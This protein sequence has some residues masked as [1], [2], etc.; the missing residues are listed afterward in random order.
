MDTKQKIILQIKSLLIVHF[1]STY[2]KLEKSLLAIFKKE[3]VGIEH[4]HKSKL[5][6][7]YGG[8]IGTNVYYDHDKECL[9]LSG[10]KGYDEND[11]FNSLNINKII[12]FSRKNT[13]IDG[14]KFDIDSIQNKSLSFPFH[15]SCNKLINMRNKLAHELDLINFKDVDIIENL[16]SKHVK[17]N[18][19]D[20]LDGL[21][22]S[23]MDETSI[24]IFSNLVYMNKIITQLNKYQ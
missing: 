19:F 21:D 6:F 4:K 5:Y 13:L 9:S 7:I 8:L 16:S 15:D 3:I 17:E 22:I 18:V 11:L 12:K 1:I 20:W 14:F 24:A 10:N 2:A 23:L